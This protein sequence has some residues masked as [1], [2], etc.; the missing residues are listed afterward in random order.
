MTRFLFPL[1]VALAACENPASL[2]SPVPANAR[3]VA[4]S[5]S[6]SSPGSLA[7]PYKTIQKC[8]S[9]VPSGWTCL[10]R[11]GVYRET[12]TPNSR[13]RLEPYNNESVTVDGSDP[14]TGWTPYNGKI[15]KANVALNPELLANQVFVDN[16]MMT[17]ARWPNGGDDPL[18]PT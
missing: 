14:V 12:V 6:D 2:E 1:L 10:I 8:A 9:S 17:T 18:H 7:A 16:A 4:T 5:G 3:V 11:A 13:I 15:Y